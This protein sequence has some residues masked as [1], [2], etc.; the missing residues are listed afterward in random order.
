MKKQ[1][2]LAL[3]FLNII[4]ESEYGLYTITVYLDSI[5]LQGNSNAEFIKRILIKFPNLEFKVEST[6]YLCAA[7]ATE[8]TI[9]RIILT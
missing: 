3:D 4:G 7:I 6:G 2:E 9:F 8:N 5:S 1:L